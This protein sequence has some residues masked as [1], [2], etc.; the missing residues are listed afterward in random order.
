MYN[1]AAENV[2]DAF[3]ESLWLMRASGQERQSRNGPVRRLPGPVMITYK[4]PTRRVLFSSKRD[5]NPYFHLMESLWMLYG[6]RDVKW[7]SQFSSNIGRYSD[8]GLTFH[9]AYG[10]RWRH[11]FMT[12]QLE[13]LAIELRKDPDTRRAVLAMWDAPHDLA[14][15]ATGGKDI[16]CNTHA[17]FEVQDGAVNLTVCNRS[18][19][20]V[21]GAL[22]A[23]AVHFA[24]LLEW[25]A[26]RTGFK[27]GQYRQFTNNL[28][29]YEPHWWMM[30]DA[31]ILNSANDAEMA[32][33][34]PTIPLAVQSITHSLF[35]IE[36]DRFMT[37]ELHTTEDMYSVPFFNDVAK[38]MILSWNYRKAGLGQGVASLK[39]APPSDWSRAA[40]EWLERRDAP[41]AQGVRRNGV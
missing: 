23:N 1:I 21:W 38:P 5:C 28:H 13:W 4:D 33:Y 9:G 39:A 24:F 32:A 31:Q 34:P 29:I 15:M 10:H 16:P 6:S 22:G 41:D 3:R 20:L 25:M 18:N 8:D 27:M 30:E 40:M 19:D 36:L 2:N 26:W 17:Y 35:D 14:K 11:H 12:D 37:K 7:L